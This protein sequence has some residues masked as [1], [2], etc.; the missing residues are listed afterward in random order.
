[1][2]VRALVIEKQHV[3]PSEFER[4]E[5]AACYKHDTPIGVFQERLSNNAAHAPRRIKMAMTKAPANA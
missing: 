3:T 5:G 4:R 2:S 1:M